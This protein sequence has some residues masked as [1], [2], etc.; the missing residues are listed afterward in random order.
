MV[1]YVEL[2][3]HSAYSFLDGAS[4]PE[5]LAA[6]AAEL[7]ERFPGDRAA[8]ARTAEVAERLEFDLTQELGYRYPDFSDGAVTAIK[9]LATVCFDA[10]S[11]RYPPSNNLLLGG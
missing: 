3:C 10:F 11:E 4:Q 1:G 7:E 6:R 5:E 8:V 9:Q 2:H